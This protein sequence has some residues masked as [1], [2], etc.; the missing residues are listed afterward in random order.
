MARP[1]MLAPEELELDTPGRLEFVNWKK[2]VPP[3]DKEN[4]RLYVPL[5]V[6]NPLD[7]ISGGTPNERLVWWELLRLGG[8]SRRKGW[9]VRGEGSGNKDFGDPITPRYIAE[10]LKLPPELML[11]GLRANM[12]E[13]RVRWNA[14]AGDDK[15]TAEYPEVLQDTPKYS[16]LPQ[17]IPNNSG[18]GATGHENQTPAHV[19]KRR[20]EKRREK[21]LRE[22]DVPSPKKPKSFSDFPPEIQGFTNELKASVKE[23]IKTVPPNMNTPVKFAKWEFSTADAIDKM[24]RIDKVPYHEIQV[25]IDFVRNDPTCGKWKGWGANIQSGSKLREK[26]CGK[27]PTL[28]NQMNAKGKAGVANRPSNLYIEGNGNNYA[29]RK[30]D[31]E[32]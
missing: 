25:A 17:S 26:Y 6:F 32:G 12:R 21:K 13:K 14:A 15:D 9:I 4:V 22:E 2:Y 1:K 18:D 24:H 16:N 31:A 10:I 19:P 28:F 29:D 8:A 11:D 3:L 30:P 23:C 20:E 7:T 27:E 5:Y